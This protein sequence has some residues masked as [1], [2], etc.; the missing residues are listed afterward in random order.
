MERIQKKFEG[1]INPKFPSSG[2][3]PLG[4]AHGCIRDLKRS[5]DKCDVSEAMASIGCAFGNAEAAFYEKQASEEEMDTIKDD[6]ADLR[7]KFSSKCKCQS[8]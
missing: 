2:W 7:G 6:A 1:D 3:D 5:V 4:Y 8:R